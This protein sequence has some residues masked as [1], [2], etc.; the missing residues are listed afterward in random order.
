[1]L[2][3]AQVDIMLG[4]LEIGTE[5]VLLRSDCPEDVRRAA[6]I[7]ARHN[8]QDPTRLALPEQCQT[9]TVAR[10]TPVGIADR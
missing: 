5:G 3:C 1:M 4:A 8:D 2:G 6:A 10:I 9:A 7:L